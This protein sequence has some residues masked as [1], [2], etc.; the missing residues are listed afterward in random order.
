[1]AKKRNSMVRTPKSL[2]ISF[3]EDNRR[4]T[5]VPNLPKTFRN[6]KQSNDQHKSWNHQ[7]QH[8]EY[9]QSNFANG[10]YR[11]FGENKNKFGNSKFVTSR[12]ST[13]NQSNPSTLS[14]TYKNND[15]YRVSNLI[16]NTT[17][18]STDS[19]INHMNMTLLEQTGFLNNSD[20]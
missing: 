5:L 2:T 10:N 15:K 8:N 14:R 11:R 16:N 3:V 9:I 7:V 20:E 13:Q 12:F 19:G 18:Y 4:N 6:R 1:M 17:T